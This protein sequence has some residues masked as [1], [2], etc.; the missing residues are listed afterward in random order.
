MKNDK[1]ESACETLTELSGLTAEVLAQVI[2]RIDLYRQLRVERDESGKIVQFE[3]LTEHE[4]QRGRDCCFIFEA[5]DVD[6]VGQYEWSKNS[7]PGG[8][9]SRS[10]AYQIEGTDWIVQVTESGLDI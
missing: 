3:F 6:E 5:D 7:S 2:T 9:Y 4:D 8:K 10:Q 1:L